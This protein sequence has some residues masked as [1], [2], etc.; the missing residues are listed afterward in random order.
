M[1]HAELLVPILMALERLAYTPGHAGTV[2]GMDGNNP[3][4]IVYHRIRAKAVELSELRRHVG[5]SRVNMPV[6]QTTGGGTLGQGEAVVGLLQR[7]LRA[8]A[9]GNVLRN[10]GDAV[11]LA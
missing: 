5:R 11:D 1:D 10:P 8:L 3:G 7:L 6:P 2:L 4:R 9:L